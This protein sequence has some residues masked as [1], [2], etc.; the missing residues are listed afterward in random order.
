MLLEFTNTTHRHLHSTLYSNTS[1]SISFVTTTMLLR[2]V[3]LIYFI[4]HTAGNIA[5]FISP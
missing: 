1:Q 2:L 4:T 5:L 3:L